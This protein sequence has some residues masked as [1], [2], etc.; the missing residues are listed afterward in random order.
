MAATGTLLIVLASAATVHVNYHNQWTGLFCIGDHFPLPPPLRANSY[1]FPNSYGFDG[2]FYRDIAHDPFNQRGFGQYIDDPRLRYER[3]LLPV[4]ANFLA[5]GRESWID[6]VYIGLEW[7]SAFLGVYW[8]GRFAQLEGRSAWWGM[9]YLALPCTLIALDRMLSD[10]PFTTLCV[11]FFYFAYRTQWQ[12]MFLTA[13]LACLAREMGVLLV[14]GYMAY[15]LWHRHFR[16]GIIFAGALIPFAV[17]WLV[18]IAPDA[19]KALAICL[20]FLPRIGHCRCTEHSVSFCA[21]AGDSPSSDILS[22]LSFVVCAMLL[23]SVETTSQRR[24]VRSRMG[25]RW[26]CVAGSDGVMYTE[27]VQSCL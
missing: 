14:G 19:R 12:G 21:A 4:M 15:L 27:L 13:M 3:I 8:V 22:L 16:R 11:G 17:W 18:E 7:L 25:G 2:Q 10:L 6:G 26:I 20:L 1:V 24:Y 23:W 5:L 9:V